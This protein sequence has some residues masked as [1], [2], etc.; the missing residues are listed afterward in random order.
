MV[1]GLTVPP[2]QRVGLDPRH[3]PFDPGA[4]GMAGPEQV[5]VMDRVFDLLDHG[6]AFPD[7]GLYLLIVVVLRPVQLAPGVGVD[8]HGSATM[9]WASQRDRTAEVI[10]ISA[11]RSLTT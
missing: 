7:G 9:V 8:H 4:E 2:G 3:E 1:D 11:R 6:S 5:Q 10:K